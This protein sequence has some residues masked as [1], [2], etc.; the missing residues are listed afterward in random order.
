MK[1]SFEAE[2]ELYMLVN[3]A[4][5]RA[6]MPVERFIAEVLRR[7]VVAPHIMD[8]EDVMRAYTECGAMNLEIANF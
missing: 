8:N 3:A 7:F 4:S 5:E 1:I 2:E 6:K